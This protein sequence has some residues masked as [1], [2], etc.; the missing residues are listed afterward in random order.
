M[1]IPTNRYFLCDPAPLREV[2]S[3]IRY[4]REG[5]SHRACGAYKGKILRLK[6][7]S[8]QYENNFTLEAADM[9]KDKSYAEIMNSAK[10][11]ISG[12]RGNGDRVAKR[13][14]D[15]AFVPHLESAQKQARALDDEQED[16]K[17]KLKTAALDS[18]ISS[19]EKL[20]SEA[21]KVVK[22]EMEKKPGRVSVSWIPDE[23]AQQNINGDQRIIRIE[24]PLLNRFSFC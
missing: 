9:G 8:L 7:R 12:L 10:V 13:G 1:A 11:M 16:L 24:N 17:A 6:S 19:L 18:T 21:R 15:A 2:Y 5:I 3:L 4:M 14:C 20:I 23:S 22:L